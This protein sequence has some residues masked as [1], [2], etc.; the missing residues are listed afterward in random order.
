MPDRPGYGR[1]VVN[2][3]SAIV[4]LNDN[5]VVWIADPAGR[6]SSSGLSNFSDQLG[7]SGLSDASG[8]L[9]SS[10][11]NAAGQLTG[12]Y[13][14]NTPAPASSPSLGASALPSTIGGSINSS[15]NSLNGGA[16]TPG[17]FLPAGT[18][19]SP[20]PYGATGYGTASVNGRTVLIDLSNN[21]IIS[22]LH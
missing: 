13:G 22:V 5:R 8:P 9:G 21:R 17:S 16:L 12:V 18:Q 19:T 3:R 14:P 1:A 6:P 20:T 4:D 11:L 2:D 10:P 7:S 15:I